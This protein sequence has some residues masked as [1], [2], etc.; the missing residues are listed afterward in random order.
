MIS[1]LFKRNIFKIN[2]MCF[3]TFMDS[4]GIKCD[5][6]N[7]HSSD[8]EDCSSGGAYSKLQNTLENNLNLTEE[9][10]LSKIKKNCRYDIRRCEREG[11]E[12]K[13]YYK[14][15][16]TDSDIIKRFQLTYNKMFND[17][18]VPGYQFNINLIYSGVKSG[19]IVITACWPKEQTDLVVYHAY[20]CDEKR[21]ML[22]YSASPLWSD[23][24]K[25]TANVIGRVNKYSHWNDMLWFKNHRYDCYEWGGIHSVE[26]PNGIDKFKME[27]GGE[28]ISYY[29]Y[30]IPK[31]ILGF[32]YVKLVKLRSKRHKAH[33]D[34]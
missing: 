12:H 28:L 6:I 20:L 5:V 25:Q 16:L 19:N 3:S 9:E 27:F 4:K 30:T 29:N 31:S 14:D 8:K 7:M 21:T 32:A 26:N 22:L 2:Q 13:V 17:K 10:L 33:L 11:V 15:V 18:N 1:F 34:K 24:D 23:G